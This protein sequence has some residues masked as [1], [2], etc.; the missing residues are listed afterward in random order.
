MISGGK[1]CN[2]AKVLAVQLV[3]RREEDASNKKFKYDN[4]YIIYVHNIRIGKP[5]LPPPSERLP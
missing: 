3:K 4:T 5:R 2:G 1:W